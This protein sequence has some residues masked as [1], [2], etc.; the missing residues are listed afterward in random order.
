MGSRLENTARSLRRWALPVSPERRGV[1]TC[2]AAPH[3]HRMVSEH[4]AP[5]EHCV[6]WAG[7]GGRGRSLP[8]RA[9][10]GTRKN[11]RFAIRVSAA[12]RTGVRTPARIAF[13]GTCVN[14]H[15]T[16]SRSSSYTQVA[17]DGRGGGRH[18]SAARPQSSHL[19]PARLA[20]PR[21][22]ATFRRKVGCPHPPV[23]SVIPPRPVVTHRSDLAEGVA[24]HLAGRTSPP[25]SPG[26]PHPPLGS[27]T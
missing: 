7:R 10:G 18:L 21:A 20:T 15:A 24:D 22:L 13:D 3:T 26:I 16:V 1:P 6:T 12:T 8:G 23:E 9:A 25:L 14:P 11:Y 17:S 27:V 5:R 4:H 19:S 2:S